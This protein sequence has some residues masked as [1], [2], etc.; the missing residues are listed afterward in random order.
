MYVIVGL[1]NPGR[2]YAQTR[3]NMGFITVDHLAEKMNVKINKLKFKAL[4]GEMRLSG[5]KVLLVKPQ[6]FMNLSGESLREVV[7]F[8]KVD[9]DK[10]LLI[11]DDLDIET[12]SI[13]IR[14]KGSAGTHN[15][16]RSVIRQLGFD[17]FP[18]IRIGIGSNGRTDIIDY[19]TGGFTGEEAGPL[20]KA[21]EQA[22]SAVECYIEEGIEKAMNRYNGE[23]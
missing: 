16:M 9:H 12:G 3:H 21:V 1:G 17:D 18:R 10:L 6:T 7:N 22:C 20:E 2:K 14:K 23:C 8:Y 13:R 11:Y 19:V 4:V 15:G 5:H